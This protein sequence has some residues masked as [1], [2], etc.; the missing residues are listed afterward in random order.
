MRKLILLVLLLLLGVL[1]AVGMPAEQTTNCPTPRLTVG[2][3][4]RVTEG[5]ANRVRDKA[6][7]SGKEVA[8]IPGGGV[9]SVLAGPTCSE[10]FL[11]WQV[12]YKGVTGWTVEGN[13][14]GYFVEPVNAQGVTAT[15]AVS[16]TT[17]A[18]DAQPCPAGTVKQPRLVVGMQGQ[19][20]STT[21]SRLRDKPT[22]KGQEVTQIKGRGLFT[23]LAGPVCGDGLNWWKVDYNG[24]TGWT[25][26]GS[27]D[28]YF[29][30]PVAATATPTA[31]HTATPTYTPTATYTPSITPTPT[32]TLTPSIT[33]TPSNTPTQT[34]TLLSVT[35]SVSWSLDG[36]LL[37][38]GTRDGL[39]VY[40]TASFDPPP[41]QL[42]DGS[43]ARVR[44]SPADSNRLLVE[45]A[46][47]EEVS[48]WDV[49]KR[50]QLWQTSGKLAAFSGDGKRLA[51]V[52]NSRLNLLNPE[53]GSI[54]STSPDPQVITALA[55]NGDGSLALASYPS[56]NVKNNAHLVNL[57]TWDA[58]DLDRGAL[59][60]P[61]VGMAV[62]FS[63]DGTRAIMG[64][65]GGNLQMWD[66]ASGK[67]VASAI[68]GEGFSSSTQ[69]NAIVFSPDGRFIASAEGQPQ[70]VVRVFNA[71][72]LKLF[73]TVSGNYLSIDDAAYSPDGARLATAGITAQ[74]LDT[75]SYEP[76]TS[77][78]LKR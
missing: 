58:R 19:V 17:S 24:A 56:P 36:K 5:T 67:R 63:P 49:A 13:A 51:V 47:T 7:R 39:F 78:V 33:P 69:V 68:R 41:Q 70:G 15:L 31:T 2:G 62:A 76:I 12:E 43:V 26:E 61:G 27:A 38:V 3:E 18:G 40:D 64:D 6:S 1:P 4:G 73:D 65:D 59:E 75:A 25:A 44:F 77:L 29:L 60:R 21:P 9:F 55:L 11:W 72:D 10:G 8:Q 30:D 52:A 46:E 16:L 20:N 48:L 54:I 35:Q 50:E 23:V 22:T 71:T 57:S 66:V 28:E 14:S 32:V 74:I 42:L 45:R 34:P 53:D 37:A